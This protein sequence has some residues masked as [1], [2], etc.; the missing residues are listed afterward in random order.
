MPDNTAIRT[1]TL[2]NLGAPAPTVLFVDPQPI[3]REGLAYRAADGGFVVVAETGNRQ[4][5]Q[6]LV[7]RHHP[8]LAVVDIVLDLED[9]LE[10]VGWIH[11]NHKATRV[12]VFSL[13]DP[14]I[15][16]ERA[17]RAGALGYVGKLEPVS[18]LMRAMHSVLAGRMHTPRALAERLAQGVRGRARDGGTGLIDLLTDRELQVFELL[19]SGR[20]TQQIA[21][22]LDLSIKT[23]AS[24]RA[25]IQR[26]LGITSL[27][28][29]TRRA[30]LWAEQRPHDWTAPRVEPRHAESLAAPK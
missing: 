12:L 19:G 30:V 25:H 8:D 21:S 14:V 18:E 6:A 29:L 4:E 23:I 24:H 5:A 10:L 2:K 20:A 15:Y 26:K 9:G 16:G 13:R 1:A 11:A 17:L 22:A 28:E 3:V 27:G 7:A